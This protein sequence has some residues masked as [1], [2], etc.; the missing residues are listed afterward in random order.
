M[1]R[2][3]IQLLPS[4]RTFK[5]KVPLSERRKKKQN[6]KHNAPCIGKGRKGRREGRREGRRRTWSRQLWKRR[7]RPSC[8]KRR[9][10]RL[11][12]REGRDSVTSA[13]AVPTEARLQKW[14]RK[15]GCRS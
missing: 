11:R 3:D 1:L 12:R 4:A 15:R 2:L 8:R 13:N 14:K 9:I 6:R 7:R 10:R 5:T